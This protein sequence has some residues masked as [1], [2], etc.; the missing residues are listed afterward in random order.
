MV[1]AHLDHMRAEYSGLLITQILEEVAVRHE[2]IKAVD[3]R[4]GR[5]MLRYLKTWREGL[6]P[7]HSDDEASATPGPV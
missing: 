2:V 5:D 7:M 1:V 6:E 3:G 4:V